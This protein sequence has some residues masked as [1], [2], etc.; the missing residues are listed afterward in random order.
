MPQP[1]LIHARTFTLEGTLGERLK[2]SHWTIS[3]M[4]ALSSFHDDFTLTLEPL[5]L[6]PKGG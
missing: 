5:R 3:F 1:L 6:T 4:R 2:V